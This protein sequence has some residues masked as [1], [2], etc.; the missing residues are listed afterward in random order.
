MLK[1]SIVAALVVGLAGCSVTESQTKVDVAIQ[2]NLPK[3]CDALST[4]YVA[5]AAV[6]ATGKIKESTVKKVEVS[7]EGV[8]ILCKDP[9]NATAVDAVIRVTQ[10]VIVVTNGLKEARRVS[11]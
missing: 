4:A 5:F 7:Y 3:V 10:A 11:A 9:A 2:K 1:V 8:Q 6:A